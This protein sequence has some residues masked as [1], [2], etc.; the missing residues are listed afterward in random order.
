MRR[1]PTNSGFTLV[2]LL[3]VI[4]II[5]VLVALLLPAVQAARESA[6]RMK[7]TASEKQI[8][9]ALH[10][11]HDVHQRFPS[12]Q[13]FCKIPPCIDRP[14]WWQGWGWSASILPYIEQGA[15]AS[16]FDFSRN[17][18]DPPN[19]TL[20]ATPV[21]LFH[22]PSD[23]SRKPEIPPSGVATAPQR[24]ATSNY[25]GNGGSFANSFETD[26]AANFD[27]VWTNG[28]LRRDS[29]HRFADIID[30]TANTILLGE[31]THFNFTWDPTMYGH[32][33]VPS[34][35][36][37]CTLALVRHGNQPLNPPPTANNVV[38]REGFHSYHPGGANFAMCD[39]SVRFISE[40]IHNTS[41]QRTAE[42]M[43]NLFDAANY[44]IYQRL[45][46]RNDGLSLGDF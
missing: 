21:K 45:F 42:T 11:Y 36:A 9:L 3:V 2:E 6:R 44:G 13:Y 40:T 12:G 1:P 38:K 29:K 37:C 43:D 16:Q 35:T 14:Q 23:K 22:C 31:V 41:R 33:D 34:G 19:V 10:N 26:I 15:L 25:C 24:L 20:I 32:W 30:G 17:L 46:S 5:G 27:E 28:V 7:C 4:A 39:G 8:A 18:Y